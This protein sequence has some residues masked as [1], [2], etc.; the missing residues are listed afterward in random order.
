MH[1]IQSTELQENIKT[2]YD[3]KEIIAIITRSYSKNPLYSP[4]IDSDL[5]VDKI[6]YLL[7]DAHHTGV[8]YGFIDVERIIRTLDV[9]DEKRL[10]ILEKGRQA[11][12]NLLVARYHMYQT[13]YYHKTVTAF[14]LALQRIYEKLLEENLAYDI[15]AIYK[16]DDNTLFSFNDSYI[17]KVIEN[18]KSSVVKDLIS[19]LRWRIP[20]KLAYFAPALSLAGQATEQYHKL[21]LLELSKH[22]DGLSKE[23]KIDRDWIFYAR[24]PA[25]ELLSNPKDETA[26]RLLL[27]DGTSMP[28]VDYNRSIIYHLYKYHF[29]DARVYTNERH[30]GK[31]SMA[32]AKYFDLG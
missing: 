17:W 21:K 18:A 3:P 1:I 5:D 25:L 27:D 2:Q 30:L 16:L 7:R 23:A 4:L 6:D 14:E 10:A 13:V 28:L 12:E 11:L 24:P 31:L 32:I 9:D 22:I 8:T 15:E 19:Y 26:I 20:L 29:L